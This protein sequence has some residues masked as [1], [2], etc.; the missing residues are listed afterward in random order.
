MER[1]NNKQK[2]RTE[3]TA[4]KYTL[5]TYLG[6]EVAVDTSNDYINASRLVNQVLAP[7]HGDVRH[8]RQPK[9]L[10]DWLTSDGARALINYLD[11]YPEC[12]CQTTYTVD[13]GAE[14]QRGTYVH[15]RLTA[16]VAQWAC[17]IL[18]D[19]L[20]AILEQRK[21]SAKISADTGVT[22][23]PSYS[24]ELCELRNE[25]AAAHEAVSRR[26]EVM[27]VQLGTLQ[28]AAGLS[29]TKFARM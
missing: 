23:V 21:S 18:A 11:A 4:G 28:E 27:R 10:R 12:I 20:A 8:A 9:Q 1:G 22:A 24:A 3:L 6:L 17:P 19:K 5:Y 16:C 25:V 2:A 14:W 26:L 15:P 29:Q 13:D 7:Q